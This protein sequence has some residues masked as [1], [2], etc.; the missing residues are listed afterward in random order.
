MMLVPNWIVGIEFNRFDLRTKTYTA[1]NTGS[2]TTLTVVDINPN[3]NVLLVRVSYQLGW[4]G[5]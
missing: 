4:G 5:R 3:I 2:S 1:N